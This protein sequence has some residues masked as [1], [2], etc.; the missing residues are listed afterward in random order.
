MMDPNNDVSYLFII[1]QI[2]FFCLLVAFVVFL[3]ISDR[4]VSKRLDEEEQAANDVNSSTDDPDR[5]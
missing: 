1:G 3:A 4:R 5:P 2:M